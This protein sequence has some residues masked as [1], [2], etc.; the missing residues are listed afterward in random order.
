MLGDFGGWL[1][2]RSVPLIVPFKRYLILKICWDTYCIDPLLLCNDESQAFERSHRGALILSN[3]K[4]MNVM[5]RYL[6]MRV[7]YLK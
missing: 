5:L 3:M 4:L 6:R 2:V 1:A 7:Y